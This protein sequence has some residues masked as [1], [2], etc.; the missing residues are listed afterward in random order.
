MEGPVPQI[1]PADAGFVGPERVEFEERGHVGIRGAGVQILR[2]LFF[3]AE[4]V[5][6]DARKVRSSLEARLALGPLS[7]F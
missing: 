3:R 6:K 2:R 5:P 7:Q 1:R 4:A